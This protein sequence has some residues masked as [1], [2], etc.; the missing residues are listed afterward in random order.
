MKVC[1]NVQWWIS[2][3]YKRY[4]S[5]LFPVYTSEL[6]PCKLLI[7]SLFPSQW[8]GNTKMYTG[9]YGW[10]V[11]THCDLEWWHQEG[12]ISTP[13]I[14]K[15]PSHF[16]PSSMK[17]YRSSIPLQVDLFS[18]YCCSVAGFHTP[19][20]TW[21]LE[22]YFTINFALPLFKWLFSNR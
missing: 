6:I 4:Q 12:S 15:T 11:I 13:I 10:C 2:I 21:N 7:F 18:I 16:A 5:K 9:D 17:G 14:G 8:R 3:L 19:E 20:F 1:N 22:F